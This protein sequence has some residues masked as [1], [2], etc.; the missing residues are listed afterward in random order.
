MDIG[1]SRVANTSDHAHT[2]QNT[3]EVA[4]FFK[5]CGFGMYLHWIIPDVRRIY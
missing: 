1:E 3:T 5:A 2:I 4:I